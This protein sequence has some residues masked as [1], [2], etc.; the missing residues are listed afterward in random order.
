MQRSLD[1]NGHLIYRTAPEHPKL[2]GSY[3]EHIML[4]LKVDLIFGVESRTS[5][6]AGHA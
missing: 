4:M 6:T 3:G 5:L 1:Q 2:R